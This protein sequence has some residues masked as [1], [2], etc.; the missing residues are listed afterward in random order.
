MLNDIG[1]ATAIPIPESSAV[2]RST[3]HNTSCRRAPSAIRT[4]ISRVLRATEYA[5]TPYNPIA[6]SSVASAPKKLESVA[7]MRSM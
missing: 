2:C 3:I 5:I 7:I 6:A 4:P 1:S